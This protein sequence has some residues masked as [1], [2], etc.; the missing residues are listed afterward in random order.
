MNFWENKR[1]TVTG[2]SG[3]LGSFIVEKLRDRGCRDVFV[4]EIEDY[5]LVCMEDVKKMYKDGNPDIV[6]HLAAVVGGIGANKLN[7]GKY[8][9]DN[10]MMGVQLIEEGRQN[11]LKKF[12][13]IGTICAYPKFTPV[14]FKEENLWNGYPEETNAPYGLA[15][16]M[17]LVQSQAYR[18]QYGF[19]SIYLLPVNLYGPRDNFNLKTSHVIPAL[20]RKCV[21][22]AKAKKEE[23]VVWGTGEA[24]R[25]F[26]YVEDAAEGILLAAEKYDKPDPVNLGA[27]FEIKIKDLVEL[28]VKLTGFK[29]KIVWDK[30]KPDGQ[31]RR[32]LD[33]SRAEKE[34]G[35]KAKTSFEEGLK[36]T[37]KWYQINE[38]KAK[39]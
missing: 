34:F 12:V 2:G 15:K 5:N 29:G 20:V 27:G 4:P 11:N 3:F 17:L 28:I 30:T 6:I 32:M 31:P 33:V 22:A 26:F 24:S 39:R 8:F 9:Y 38:T 1:V 21:E 23:V 10:L 16:K 25:E 37:I 19:N 13:A 36:K 35:F 7:P 18:E 14:P